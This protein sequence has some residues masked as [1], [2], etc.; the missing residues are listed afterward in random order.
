MEDDT[1]ECEEVVCEVVDNEGEGE[2]LGET[3]RLSGD[4]PADVVDDETEKNVG[5]LARL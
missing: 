4:D 2:S 5:N 3:S 1:E